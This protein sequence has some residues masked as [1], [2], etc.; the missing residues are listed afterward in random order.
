MQ[1]IHASFIPRGISMC[2]HQW[3]T[4][5]L[6]RIQILKLNLHVTVSTYTCTDIHVL[7]GIKVSAFLRISSQSMAISSLRDLHLL[8]T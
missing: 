2:M 6:K 1:H 8:H 7:A 4:H 3:D 5:V